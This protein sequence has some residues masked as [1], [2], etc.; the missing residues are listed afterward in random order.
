MMYKKNIMADDDI[1]GEIDMV[2][3]RRKR[4]EQCMYEVENE[5]RI[6]TRRGRK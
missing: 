5:E 3:D 4:G 6:K 1:K 2:D